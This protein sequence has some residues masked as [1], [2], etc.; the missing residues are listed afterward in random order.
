MR[1]APRSA[2]L[3][4]VMVAASA[5]A[6]VVA[7]ET[8]QYYASTRE[9]ADSADVL[10]AKVNLEIRR[11]LEALAGRGPAD[12]HT[13]E[14][15][16]AAVS[17]HFR[18][19]IL[20]ELE[21]WLLNSAL[22]DRI[23]AD[24]EEEM[25]YREVGGFGIG[26][27]FD[28]GG[29]VPPSPT[30][31]L[32]GVRLGTDKLAHFISQGWYY[33]TWAMRLRAEG[34]PEDEVE[35]RMI[36]RGI[37]LEKTVLGMTSSG[38]FS[39]AD[40]EANYEGFR[41]FDDLCRGEEPMLALDPERGWTL[42]RPFEIANYVTPE[43]DESYNPSIFRARRW[44]KVRPVLETYCPLLH[45]PVVAER[46]ARYAAR[47]RVTPT[48]RVLA[49]RVEDGTLPDPHAYSLD[50]ICE[51]SAAAGT[52]G[53]RLSLSTREGEVRHGSASRRP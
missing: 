27:P 9:L 32:D 4:A 26:G 28:I 6:P 49:G 45:D 40:L 44:R 25:R 24:P 34:L 48:E 52:N 10:D 53:A 50:A 12:E 47:D 20:H 15:A 51:E 8:D 2:A 38:V 39:V 41:F 19:F 5:V 31:Q 42:V 35:R 17:D 43:W 33:H 13:C 36:G 1:S 37:W 3:L 16:S 7:L 14:D 29:W 46:F 21:L 22:V 30:I 23:P 18:Q 11:A